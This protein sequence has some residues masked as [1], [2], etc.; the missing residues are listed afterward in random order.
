MKSLDLQILDTCF[1]FFNSGNYSIESELLFGK[2]KKISVDNQVLINQ[3]VDALWEENFL[4]SSNGKYYLTDKALEL[5]QKLK[6]KK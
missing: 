6:I 2:L 5:L 3:R 1:E 4:E